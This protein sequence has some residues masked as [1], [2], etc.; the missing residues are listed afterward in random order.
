MT[1]KK[2]APFRVGLLDWHTRDL[3]GHGDHEDGSSE[4][5]FTGEVD[6][7]GK[8]TFQPLHGP[9]LYLFPDE[10]TEWQPH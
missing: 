3:S 8:R 5:Y 10:L 9:T 1:R 7:W 4:G 2:I 6:T